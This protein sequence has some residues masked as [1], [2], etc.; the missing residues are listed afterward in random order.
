MV[1]T[2]EYAKF[3]KFQEFL[4]ECTAVTSPVESGKGSPIFYSN[5]WV[6]D[7]GTIDYITDNSNIFF[8][9]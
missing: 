6:I 8:S 1:L 2:A 7:S 3:F 9:F 4:K 5:K